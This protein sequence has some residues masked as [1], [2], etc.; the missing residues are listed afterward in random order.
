[1]EVRSATYDPI[2]DTFRIEEAGSVPG[3]D[4]ETFRGDGLGGPQVS[5]HADSF[6]FAL[7]Q[8]AAFDLIEPGSSLDGGADRVSLSSD[9]CKLSFGRLHEDVDMETW[10]LSRGSEIPYRCDMDLRVLGPLEAV[11]DGDPVPLGGPKQRLVLA[12]LVV[13]D[14]RSLSVDALVDRVWG[15]TQPGDAR[16]SIHTYVSRLRAGLGDRLERGAGGYVLHLATGEVD[17]RRFERLLVDAREVLGGDPTESARLLHEGLAMWR[18]PPYAD[19]HDEPAL[20]G[21]IVR[22]E[23]LRMA[24]I[25]DRIE[26]DL[27]LGRHVGL[28]AELEGLTSDYPLRERFRSQHM[29]ALY[30]SG[31]Q[32]EALRAYQT[33][34]SVLVE[35]FGIDPSTELQQLEERMLRHDPCLELDL[36]P[37]VSSIS[38]GIR[39]RDSKLPPT[40]GEE[41]DSTIGAFLFTDV[42]DSTLLWETDQSSMELALAG[43]D[44]IVSA[45]I[46]AAGGRV[47]KHSGDGMLSILPDV[48]SA[49]VAAIDANRGFAVTEWGRVGT[50]PVRMAIDFGEAR[51]RNDDLAGPVLNRCNRL[52]TLAQA[53]QVLL[54]AA[55]LGALDGHDQL[56]IVDLGERRLKGLAP[57]HVYR[58]VGTV[59]SPQESGKT[60]SGGVDRPAFV[61]H[62]RGYALQELVGEGAVSTVYRAVQESTGREVA[63]KVIRPQI[64]A[65]ARFVRRFEVEAKLVAE[66]EH[67]HILTLYDY[68]RDRDSAYLV[69]RFLRGGNLRS[70]ID[71]GAW[72]LTPALR[73]LDQVG[74]ALWYAHRQGIVH[75]DVRP[76]NV[77]LDEN[78]N[79]HLA[80]FGVAARAALTSHFVGAESEYITPEERRGEAF[81]SRSDLYCLGHLARELLT[82]HRPQDSPHLDE[83]EHHDLPPGLVEV[84]ARAT[85]DDTDDRFET[86]GDFLD[87]LHAAVD[88]VDRRLPAGSGGDGTPVLC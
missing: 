14:G 82:G 39:D 4:G 26:A 2:G 3:G 5:Y 18:G 16:S 52:L 44:Q 17:A 85:A 62:V 67:P 54:S 21:E 41:G 49:V 57:M 24:V 70:A 50:L 46:G 27:V 23:E 8:D 37:G 40:L 77:L 38:V 81:T 11:A 86:V 80:D 12:L 15:D 33:T 1:M 48:A 84:L 32:A 68:W 36:R 61:D 22:L 83:E 29:L 59:V 66:L 10:G 47:F 56:D 64:A 74:E 25:E 78:C 45:A 76:S 31:R 20:Q 7:L 75:R 19:L 88:R 6:L 35:E 55:A 28:V 53:G 34:A 87:G 72:R 13:A 9:R 43:H 42:E 30:R 63:I 60:A 65:D 51:V 71:R 73:L 79:A 69:M 58:L